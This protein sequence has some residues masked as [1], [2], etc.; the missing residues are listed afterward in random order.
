MEYKLPDAIKGDT[1]NG[2]QFTLKLNAMPID[3]TGA[4]ITMQVKTAAMK[5]PSLELKTMD[6]SLE[7]LDAV[8]GVFRIPPFIVALN[9]DNY[10]YDI[11][12]KFS[13]NVIKTYISGTWKIL[14]DVTF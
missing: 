14:Q 2:V 10:I 8:N 11:Q 7:I 9:A 5:K 4:E 1:F 3:L 6:N 12:F 13:S